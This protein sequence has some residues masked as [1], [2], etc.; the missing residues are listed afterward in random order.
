MM[1]LARLPQ[2]VDTWEW[3]HIFVCEL[4]CASMHA[5]ISRVA[6]LDA[7][8]L[9]ACIHV[10]THPHLALSCFQTAP[11]CTPAPLWLLPIDQELRTLIRCC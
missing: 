10:S 7:E 8:P 4:P 2:S 3:F 9:T 6:C 1:Y 5:C 11:H